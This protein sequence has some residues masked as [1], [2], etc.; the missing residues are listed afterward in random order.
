M[1]E[2]PMVTI[3]ALP[4]G[5]QPYAPEVEDYAR[6]LIEAANAIRL[7]ELFT[8]EHPDALYQLRDRNGV[9]VV[10]LPTTGL[11]EEQ[12]VKLLKYRMAQYLVVH[13]V[14][15]RKVYEARL[16]HEPVAPVAPGDV[17]VVAGN[18]ATG[19]IL[20]YAVLR[21]SPDAPPRATMRDEARPLFPAEELYG[22]GI[23]NRLRIFPDLPVRKVREI[24]RF[25][26]NQQ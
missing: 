17:H 26:K 6:G 12:L 10:A 13:F 20:C 23:F 16:E 22:W 4:T 21:D 3:A 5:A 1:R 15:H 18:S 19:E 24:G 25:M 2:K 8:A 11:R 9:A 14:D 7:P